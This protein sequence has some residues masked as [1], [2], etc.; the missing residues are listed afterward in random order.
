MWP[1]CY[2]QEFNKSLRHQ[3][4]SIAWA[5]DHFRA[6]IGHSD[7][8]LARMV[9]SGTVSGERL[10]A[11]QKAMTT[12]LK[13]HLRQMRSDDLASNS[14]EL[15]ELISMSQLPNEMQDD[16]L[17]FVRKNLELEQGLAPKTQQKAKKFNMYSQCLCS[18]PPPA[19]RSRMRMMWCPTQ[20]G[21]AVAC[22]PCAAP[23]STVP[24]ILGA[25]GL[26]SNGH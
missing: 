24:R 6:Q 25:S 22:P 9:G 3:P 19:L 13:M 15:T 10:H 23:L 26:H 2:S 12:A 21:N 14:T 1:S 18:P 20:L 5:M 17:S 8:M 11:A 7:D 16:L 4:T